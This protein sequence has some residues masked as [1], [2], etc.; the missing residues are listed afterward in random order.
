MDNHHS[1]TEEKHIKTVPRK[2][3][4]KIKRISLGIII[5]LI[6]FVVAAKIM[7]P[8][9]TTPGEAMSMA[10][11]QKYIFGFVVVYGLLTTILAGILFYKRIYRTTAII[12][13]IFLVLGGLG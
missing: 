6:F 3:F 10:D 9:V 7:S 4:H 8:S 11:N 5:A 13:I 1:G 2:R 12:V